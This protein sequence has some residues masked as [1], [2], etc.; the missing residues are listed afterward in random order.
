M[1]PES[2]VLPVPN[3]VKR[4]LVASVAVLRLSAPENVSSAPP[5]RLFVTTWL[6]AV[7]P[8]LF[9]NVTLFAPVMM[10][11]RP[12]VLPIVT[13]LAIALAPERSVLIWSTPLLKA[14]VPA[15]VPSACTLARIRVPSVSVAPLVK[16]LGDAPPIVSEPV[17]AFRTRL[18]PAVEPTVEFRIVSPLPVKVIER[19]WAA[20]EMFQVP[21]SVSVLPRATALESVY[22]LPELV[23]PPV[24]VRL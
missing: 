19:F 3:I 24:S 18:P 8:K 1:L 12:W 15:L 4:R 9:A 23:R 16:V 5:E 22:G 6:P 13:G 14:N 17:G 11:P 2:S 7:V 20:S 10:P 21:A